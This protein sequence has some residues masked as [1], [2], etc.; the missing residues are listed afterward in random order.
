M[1]AGGLDSRTA[2]M[3]GMEGQEAHRHR[4]LS[5]RLL[6]R[7]GVPRRA[8]Q[9]RQDHDQIPKCPICNEECALSPYR[10]WAPA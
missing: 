1:E 5:A 2:D 7:S 8:P 6:A 4:R 9:V 10:R 3:I